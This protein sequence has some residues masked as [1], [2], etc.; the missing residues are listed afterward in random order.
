[1]TRLNLYIT[2]IFLSFS[3]ITLSGRNH[4]DSLLSV[5]GPYLFHL[6]GGGIRIVT[7]D[8]SQQIDTTMYQSMPEN[9][10][11][12]ITDHEGN[13]GF[14]VTLHD[15]ARPDWKYEKPEKLFIMSDPHGRM[16]CFLSV[17][18]GNGII[19][20]DLNWNFGNGHLVI[21]GDVADRGDDVTQIYWLIYKLE[22]EADCAGGKVHF[23]I[24]NHETLL[25][26]DDLRYTNAK[27]KTLAKRTGH[28]YPYF[29]SVDTELG[30]W[31]CTRNTIELIGNDLFVHA[32]LSTD[33]VKRNLSIPFVN[34]MV[35][36][37]LFLSKKER[38]HR[39]EL[40]YFL[41][42]SNGPVW[43]RGLVLD[44]EKYF[45]AT[46]DDLDTILKFYRADRIFVGHTIFDEIS[47]FYNGKVIAVNVDN[48]ENMAKGTSRAIL[49]QSDTLS[50]VG[51]NGV[52]LLSTKD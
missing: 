20:N 18:K 32:G 40:I 31:L 27:Y 51:D 5:D 15:I 50:I 37:G 45:P 46:N 17:L 39:A 30:R 36:K 11:L 9:L 3:T 25:L 7:T 52:R 14:D 12:H 47:T 1:M 43:Y 28:K 6:D 16:D 13:N 10:T 41:F 24:G 22:Y 23:L 21:I 33:M 2:L 26:M 35:S 38:Q 29:W 19:D 48:P 8:S 4:P 49:I 34:E 42:R 44:E